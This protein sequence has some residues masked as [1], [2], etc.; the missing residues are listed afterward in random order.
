MGL[1]GKKGVEQDSQGRPI[2]PYVYKRPKI[3][4]KLINV[5]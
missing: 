3:D 2:K 5:E 1:C 4:L